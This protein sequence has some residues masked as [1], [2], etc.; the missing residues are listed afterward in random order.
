MLVANNIM[1]AFE[2]LLIDILSFF[3]VSFYKVLLAIEIC[4]PKLFAV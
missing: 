4:I 3:L 2:R 1:I